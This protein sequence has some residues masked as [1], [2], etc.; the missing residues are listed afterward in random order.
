MASVFFDPALGGDGSTVSDD[1]NPVTGLAAGGH[2][3]RFVPALAQVVSVSSFVVDK[4]Q[5]AKEYA[6]KVA[7]EVE[8]GTY[9]AKEHAIGTFVPT[10]S[11]KEWSTKIN[12]LVGGEDYSSKE[13]AI[14]TF[15]PSGSSKEWA[16]QAASSASTAT[17]SSA[18]AASSAASAA[19][20]ATSANLSSQSASVSAVTASNAL[21]QVLN[22]SQASGT[23]SYASFALADADK[24]NLANNEVVLVVLDETKNNQG[25]YY[26]YDGVSLVFLRYQNYYLSPSD[27][28][29]SDSV[30]N[31]IT[32]LLVLQGVI[33]SANPSLDF[34]L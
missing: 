12:S 32:K 3:L 2:R 18:Q 26:R 21:T 16:T 27:N 14:G 20:S 17:L 7:A 19:T 11:S 30:Q 28:L 13:W 34:T 31:M 5:L 9:S 15:V 1:A 29:E 8:A 10:G 4:S 25:T 24:T 22:A 33:P 23:E 6:Q